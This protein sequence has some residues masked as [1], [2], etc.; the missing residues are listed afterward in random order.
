MMYHESLYV[1]S[2]ELLDTG[3]SMGEDQVKCLFTCTWMHDTVMKQC[4]VDHEIVS[5]KLLKLISNFILSDYCPMST[6]VVC[7]SDSW[8]ICMSF[9][10]T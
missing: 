2:Y 4:I 10:S 7:D 3:F 9:K 5:E 1:A 8:S 6:R